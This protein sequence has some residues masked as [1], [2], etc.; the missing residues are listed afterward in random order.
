MYTISL[1][2]YVSIMKPD[3]LN[4][5]HFYNMLDQLRCDEVIL[6]LLKVKVQSEVLRRMLN[7]VLLA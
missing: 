2:H 3:D 4:F 6:S 1:F 7:Q 5:F